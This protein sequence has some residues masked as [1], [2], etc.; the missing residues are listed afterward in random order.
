MMA[1]DNGGLIAQK[2]VNGPEGA[3]RAAADVPAAAAGQAEAP[4]KGR[5]KP[6]MPDFIFA[7]AAFA[8]GYLFS[9]WLLFSW[10][11]W[12][13][14]VFTAAYLLLVTVYLIRK[15]AFAGGP[16]TWFWL[17]ITLATGASYALWKNPGFAGVRSLFLF[18]SAVYY[19]IVA[20]GSTFMGKSG[21]YL[22][23]DALNAVVLIPIR[24]FLNQYISF[25]ALGKGEKR[26]K[27]LPIFIGI[28][29]AVFLLIC[30]APMLMRADSGGFSVI[31]RFLADVFS[32]DISDFL[33]YALFAVPVAAYLYG[34]VSGAAHKMR[35]DTIKPEGAKMF[36]DTMRFFQPATVYIALAAVCGLY[37]IFILSQ[38]PYFFSAFTGIRP[39]G[40]LNYSEYARQ[41]FF[42]LCGISAINMTIL[43][44]ANL[45]CKKR[46]EELRLLRVLNI[47]LAVITML[48]IAT[49]FS[50]MALY[51]G[52]GGLTMPRL[53]PC[54]FMVF[55]AIVCVA[56]IVLQKRSF[57]IVRLSLV[58]GA[59]ILCVFCLAD[60]DALVIRYNSE[61]H[62]AGSLPYFDMDV[63]RRADEAG[64]V[65]AIRVY[66]NTSDED[67]KIELARYLNDF[68]NNISYRE[69]DG[70]AY[71]G[72]AHTFSM[73]LYRAAEAS[74][75]FLL[76]NR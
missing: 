74:R 41:G 12:G 8:L 31:L 60:P 6:D 73:E 39:E 51:I 23:V 29:L 22:P 32:F 18:C 59:V 43:T 67:L 33:L 26:G 61:R 49:A 50:K 34:L 3:T 7:L 5:F 45:T 48:L 11:G 62:L 4:A 65:P 54:V 70:Y 64:I 16:A 46:R 1:M 21:N 9:R 2:S 27:G 10:R 40:W 72:E 36:V 44:V 47:A 71:R 19:V 14:A 35:T 68:G 13:V 76:G 25:T 20:S 30:L 56:L 52:A 17:A 55:L 24:N 15:G 53:M 69:H 63:L 58:V 66:E 38:T 37:A 75:V 42:E 57:S 28:V